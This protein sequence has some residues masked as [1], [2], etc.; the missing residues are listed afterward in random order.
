MLIAAQAMPMAILRA[1]SYSIMSVSDRAS[2]HVSLDGFRWYLDI[3][4]WPCSFV[5][6]GRAEASPTLITH[7]RKLLYLCMY[8][9]ECVY[10]ERYV[11][12]VLI[13][14]LRICK[15]V[16][17]RAHKLDK[18]RQCSPCVNSKCSS[19]N[20]VQERPGHFWSWPAM[21]IDLGNVFRQR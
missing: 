19:P 17:M 4:L 14:Q 20:K 16:S 11:V 12:H 13:M 7:T 9:Y 18:D 1:S 10:S 15:R 3:Q 6:L 21:L 5:L 2:A 8:V